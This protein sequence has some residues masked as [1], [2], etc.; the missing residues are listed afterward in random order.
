MIVGSVVVEHRG[1]VVSTLWLTDAIAQGLT[2][3]VLDARTK[4]GETVLWS[5][6]TSTLAKALL[7]AIET[8]R[9]LRK[10]GESPRSLPKAA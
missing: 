6:V 10:A 1:A 8:S 4:L 9:A 5:T 2:V 3:Q 7:P